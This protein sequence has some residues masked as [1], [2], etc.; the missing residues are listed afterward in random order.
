MKKKNLVF[1]NDIRPLLPPEQIKEY[2]IEEAYEIVFRDF[3]QKLTGN[4]WKELE[5]Y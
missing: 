3:L 1:N 5:L 4:P 2:K